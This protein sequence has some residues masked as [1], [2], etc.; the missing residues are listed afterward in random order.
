[1]MMMMMMMMMNLQGIGKTF[2][3][4]D[5]V[6][7]AAAPDRQ[8]DREQISHPYSLRSKSHSSPDLQVVG[9]LEIPKHVPATA[10]FL[11]AG[12]PTPTADSRKLG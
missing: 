8:V 11:R 3:T 6:A 4:S 9:E 10:S 7:A 1:M 5:P 2:T 12:V